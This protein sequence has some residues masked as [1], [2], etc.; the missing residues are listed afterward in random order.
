VI[1]EDVETL[2][3]PKKN[4]WNFKI[5]NPYKKPL[6]NRKTANSQKDF[7]RLDKTVNMRDIKRVGIKTF[8]LPFVSARKPN[9]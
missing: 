8:R 3:I 7:V 9:K 1:L 2:E 5:K 4:Y 6:K